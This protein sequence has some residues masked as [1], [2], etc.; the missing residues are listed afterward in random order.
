MLLNCLFSLKLKQAIISGR[1]TLS[2]SKTTLDGRVRGLRRS[3]NYEF[4]TSPELGRVSSGF[5][6]D[7]K[8]RARHRFYG[9]L[10]YD[11]R[12]CWFFCWFAGYGNT[13]RP[14]SQSRFGPDTLL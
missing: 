9:V 11:G 2:A 3:R 13:K 14:Q 1:M 6:A 12:L 7:L 10:D 4:I 8:Q 5:T